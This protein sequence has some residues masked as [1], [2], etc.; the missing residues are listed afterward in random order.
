MDEPVIKARNSENTSEETI[1]VPASKVIQNLGYGYESTATSLNVTDI[2]SYYK[3]SEQTWY[4]NS[5]TNA[6]NSIICTKNSDNKDIVQ[7]T[8]LNPIESENVSVK[9]Q[10]SFSMFLC[11]FLY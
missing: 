7:I 2:I 1:Y 10:I 4:E 5:Y 3:K 6:I 9:A 11:S 8:A